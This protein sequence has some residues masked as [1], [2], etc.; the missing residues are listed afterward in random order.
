MVEGATDFVKELQERL[1]KVYTRILKFLK[2]LCKGSATL[3]LN[4][5]QVQ[6][7]VWL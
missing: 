7:K 2:R 5:L 6:D 1:E 3:S 4:N